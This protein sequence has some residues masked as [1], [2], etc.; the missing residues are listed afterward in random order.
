LRCF[1]VSLQDSQR[2]WRLARTAATGRSLLGKKDLPR[3]AILL[4]RGGPRGEGGHQQKKQW[5]AKE[6]NPEVGIVH[7]KISSEGQA[8]CLAVQVDDL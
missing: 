3:F 2:W 7:L 6:S 8:A 4:T 5:R 1:V